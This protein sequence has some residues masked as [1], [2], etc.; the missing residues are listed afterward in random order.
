[1]DEYISRNPVGSVT[2]HCQNT[3]GAENAITTFFAAAFCNISNPQTTDLQGTHLPFLVGLVS[4]MC[5]N[6]HNNLILTDTYIISPI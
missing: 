6:E 1:M 2:Y 5:H 3:C 4:L